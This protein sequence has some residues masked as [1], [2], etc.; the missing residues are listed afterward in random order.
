MKI[1]Y[2]TTGLQSGGAERVV[3]RLAD[4]YADRGCDVVIMSLKPLFQVLP[5]NRNINIIDLGLDRK[6]PLHLWR[7]FLKAWAFIRKFKPNTVHAHMYHANIFARIVTMVC[8]SQRLICSAH[9]SLEGGFVCDF[10]Y[11]ITDGIPY[12]STN[13]SQAACDSFFKRNASIPSR[14]IAV[15]N[16]I[17]TSRFS[18]RYTPHREPCRVLSVGRLV[19]EKNFGLLFH[20]VAHILPKLKVSLEIWL[21]G[22]GPE[23]VKLEK[24][25]DDLG[26]GSIVTFFGEHDSP[27]KLMSSV[28]LFVSTS[29]YEGFGLAVAEAMAAGIPVIATDSGG[30]SEVMG[31]TG[32]LIP[33]G[34]VLSLGD[35][36]ARYLACSD[37]ELRHS[38]SMGAKRVLE[39]FSEESWFE[40]WNRIYKVEPD[41]LGN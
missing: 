38:G 17:D 40:T 41:S 19:P 36:I 4:Y 13:V 14:M 28:T 2:I 16:G 22:D 1:L 9:S 34:D 3:C 11:R 5:L 6:T 10:L 31:E 12:I 32:C 35:E 27:E 24:L 39:N 25:A 23:R 15:P 20:A 8:P 21:V 29:N 7:A 26:L 37:S 18:T 33:V 30:V